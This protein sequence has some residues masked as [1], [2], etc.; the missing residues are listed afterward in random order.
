LPRDFWCK[1]SYII[2]FLVIAIYWQEHHRVFGPIRSY[3][4]TLL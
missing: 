2:S 4:R 1:A 3:N